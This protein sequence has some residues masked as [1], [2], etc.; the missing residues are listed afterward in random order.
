MKNKD[1]SDILAF[2]CAAIVIGI[3]IYI[4][5]LFIGSNKKL[6]IN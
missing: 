1:E 4:M 2:V 3:V 6:N 5:Y